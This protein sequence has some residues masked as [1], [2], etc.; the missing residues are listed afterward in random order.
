[1]S[2]LFTHGYAL[3]IGV[4]QSKDPDWSLPVTV[5]DARALQAILTEPTLCAYP[6]D[7]DH[8]RLLHDKGATGA[9]ILDGLAWLW[10][11]TAASSEEATA[12]VYYS[13]HGWLDQLTGEY[14]LLPHDIE[15]FDIPGSALSAR[16]FTDAL[17]GI[18]AR[19]LLVFIDS[20][21]AQG[22]ATAKDE[23]KLKLPSGF[24]QVALPK[25][26]IGDLKQG[27]G[28][29]IFTSSRGEQSSWVRSDGTLSIYT[30]H[31][32]EALQGAGNQP[33]DNLVHVS[34]LMRHLSERVP[35]SARALGKEQ[36]PFFDMA[37][38]DFPVCLVRGGKGL[39]ATGW[40]AVQGEVAEAIR[41]VSNRVVNTTIQGQVSGSTIITAGGDVT[42]GDSK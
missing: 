18:S 32:I 13:G 34:N 39:P 29:A 31:L 22:M 30:Y 12:V 1:M 2:N 7:E 35:P 40:V 37:A 14:Y 6:N 5:R 41:Q 25:G 20:C 23:P 19:R 17:R 36:T 11:Q 3:L 4:G 9:A 21:H 28:R 33:G 10:T 38:E 26:V 8:V 16:A 42:V 15:P 27:E 24:A